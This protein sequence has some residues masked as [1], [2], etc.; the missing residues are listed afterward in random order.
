MNYSL[1]M[2]IKSIYCWIKM[3]IIETSIDVVTNN[4]ISYKCPT[5]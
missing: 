5:C 3:G 2:V 1:K 4:Q